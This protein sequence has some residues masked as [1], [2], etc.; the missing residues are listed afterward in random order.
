MTTSPASQSCAVNQADKLVA[1]G[2][3]A[4]SPVM[5][6]KDMYAAVLRHLQGLS[7]DDRYGRFSICMSDHAL[8]EYVRG[9]D[10]DIDICFGISELRF[11]LVGVIHL[12]VHGQVAELGASVANDFRDRGLGS[13]LFLSAFNVAIARGIREIYLATGH[14]AACH[15]SQCLGYSIRKGGDYPK[16]I[17]V[18]D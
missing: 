17:I 7:V 14:P 15:I 3:Q 2:R 6:G 11:G 4:S 1:I 5:L 10:F 8:E 9:I 18:L 12:S 16:A 13:A